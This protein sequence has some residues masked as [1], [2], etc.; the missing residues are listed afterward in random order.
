MATLGRTTALDQGTAMP[1]NGDMN[2]NVYAC[3]WCFD[4]RP[5]HTCGRPDSFASRLLEAR[6]PSPSR[7]KFPLTDIMRVQSPIGTSQR[8]VSADNSSQPSK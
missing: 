4:T 2:V 8:L 3:R 6:S 1:K 7:T 5:F